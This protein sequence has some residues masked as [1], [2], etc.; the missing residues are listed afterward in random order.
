MQCPLISDFSGAGKEGPPEGSRWPPLQK[1]RCPEYLNMIKIDVGVRIGSGISFASL[2]R[3][4][5]RAF[6]ETGR[7]AFFCVQRAASPGA[8]HTSFDGGGV[9]AV[10]FH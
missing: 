5:G 7:A 8:R 3:Q 9:A 1:W 6:A 4:L 2:I 10:T